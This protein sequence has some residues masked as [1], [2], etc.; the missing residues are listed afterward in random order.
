MIPWYILTSQDQALV[1]VD[2]TFRSEFCHDEREHVLRL[3]LHELADVLEV[4]PQRLQQ[5]VSGDK[6][7]LGRSDDGHDTVDR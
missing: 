2:G 3:P 4:C 6:S 1:S 7:G 5:G